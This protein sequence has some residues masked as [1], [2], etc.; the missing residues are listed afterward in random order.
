MSLFG[1][2]GRVAIRVGDGKKLAHDGTKVEFDGSIGSL[3]PS[4]SSI[5]PIQPELFYDR[6]HD[7]GFLSLFQGLAAPGGMRQA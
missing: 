7:H 5:K 2:E 4:A 1:G 6:G 3:H